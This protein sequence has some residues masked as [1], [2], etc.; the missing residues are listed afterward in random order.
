MTFCS[1]SKFSS[2]QLPA[3]AE[4]SRP[5]GEVPTAAAAMSSAAGT[6]IAESLVLSGRAKTA[7][8][9][10][11]GE[12]LAGVRTAAGLAL[13]RATTWETE[14]GVAT[15]AAAG[16]PVSVEKPLFLMCVYSNVG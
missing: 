16:Q 14:W 8:T 2:F 15:M 10:D 5:A 7:L 6:A 13:A 4:K 1:C 12:R 11:S 3:V 9:I